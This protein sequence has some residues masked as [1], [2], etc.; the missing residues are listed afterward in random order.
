MFDNYGRSILADM[1]GSAKVKAITSFI[2]IAETAV[3]TP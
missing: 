1:T 2:V 3:T